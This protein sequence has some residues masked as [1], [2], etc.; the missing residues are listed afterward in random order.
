MYA[1]ITR[2]NHLLTVKVNINNANLQMEVD[3]GA[4]LSIYS[5]KT[6][7][8]LWPTKSLAPVLKYSNTT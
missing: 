6:F 7:E 4:T 2:K 5:K 3:T 8:R 1:L